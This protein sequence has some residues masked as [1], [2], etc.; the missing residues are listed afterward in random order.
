M[1]DPVPV[2]VVANTGVVRTLLGWVQPL[3]EVMHGEFNGAD[4]IVK[5]A[6]CDPAT[7]SVQRAARTAR[8]TVDT[9]QR[10][11]DTDGHNWS[12]RSWDDF[13]WVKVRADWWAAAVAAMED[14]L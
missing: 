8:A 10:M 1:T 14:R 4:V 5:F 13:E 9:W 7:Y 3:P 6:G 12:A 11:A 2:E